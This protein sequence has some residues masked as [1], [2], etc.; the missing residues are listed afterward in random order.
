MVRGPVTARSPRVG[1]H[2][3]SPNYIKATKL[4]DSYDYQPLDVGKRDLSLD[5]ASEGWEGKKCIFLTIVRGHACLGKTG[6]KV[7]PVACR[8]VNRACPRCTPDRKCWLMSLRPFSCGK[9]TPS[10][11]LVTST[12]FFFL[13]AQRRGL[14]SGFVYLHDVSMVF[15]WPSLSLNRK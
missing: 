5:A 4:L 1:N 15:V 8:Y 12:A 13:I 2:G 3:F 14:I 10:K 6:P 7:L 11:V 9:A